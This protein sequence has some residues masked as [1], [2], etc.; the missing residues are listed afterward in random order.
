MVLLLL[1]S[2]GQKINRST[3]KKVIYKDTVN[4]ML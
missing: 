1:A 2:G 3:K 4:R